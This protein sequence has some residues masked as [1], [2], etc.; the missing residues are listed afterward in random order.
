MIHTFGDSHA[1]TAH[2]GWHECKNVITH[3]IGGVLC[4]SFGNEKLNR[5]NIS[6]FN[7]NDGDSVI[8]CFGEI[9]CRNHVHKHITSENSYNNIISDLINNYFDA[10]YENIK[11]CKKKLKHISVYNV[12]PPIRYR[13]EAP[14]H[15]FPYLGSDEERKNY[16]LFFNKQLEQKCKD[17]NFIFFN[18]YDE[19]KDSDGFLKKELSDNNCHLKNGQAIKK[20]LEKNF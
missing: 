3:H 7:L 18:I 5:C 11:C 8:F 9:D 15:P 1:S 17:N 14:D 6:N 19:V 16:V 13:Y 4:Y 10:I 2:G 12:I 20:F